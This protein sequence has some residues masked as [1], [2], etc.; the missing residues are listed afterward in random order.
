MIGVSK[1]E[2]LDLDQVKCRPFGATAGFDFKAGTIPIA[3]AVSIDPR[4]PLTLGLQPA[5]TVLPAFTL[6]ISQ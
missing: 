3:G 2:A 4:Q 5:S 1:I 6:F